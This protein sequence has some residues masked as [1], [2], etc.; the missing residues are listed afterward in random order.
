MGKQELE[1]VDNQ[2]YFEDVMSKM[3]SQFMDSGYFNFTTG[4]SVCHSNMSQNSFVMGAYKGGA[5]GLESLS[6]LSRKSINNPSSPNNKCGRNDDD[7]KSI[8]SRFSRKN[9]IGNHSI[10]SRVSRRTA[11]GGG[12]GAKKNNPFNRQASSNKRPLKKSMTIGAKKSPSTD[13]D[14]ISPLTGQA[15]KPFLKQIK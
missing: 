3:N 4:E 11:G 10:R 7:N 13:K 6:L 2:S 9:S 12:T 1:E 8:K 5:G 14:A 15:P